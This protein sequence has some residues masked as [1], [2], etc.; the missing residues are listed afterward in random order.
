M[1]DWMWSHPW[2]CLVIL[3]FLFSVIFKLTRDDQMITANGGQEAD[4][5][6]EVIFKKV[7][8]FAQDG[9]LL[10]TVLIHEDTFEHGKGYVYGTNDKNK[11]VVYL[12]TGFL[13]KIEQL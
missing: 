13:V 2:I 10:E 1:V 3:L 6:D 5:A 8:I 4:S 12:T 11:D 7:S 9:K